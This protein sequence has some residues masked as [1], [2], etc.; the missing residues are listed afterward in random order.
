M[1]RNFLKIIRNQTH[2]QYLIS[3]SIKF[4]ANRG[5]DR[6]SR[7]GHRGLR[8]RGRDKTEVCEVEIEVAS[9]FMTTMDNSLIM[10]AFSS[11]IYKK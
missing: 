10:K 4:S 11:C 6:D 7:S 1:N 8:S 3:T 9:V 2:T 5:R